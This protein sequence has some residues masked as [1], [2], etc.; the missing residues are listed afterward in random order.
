MTAQLILPAQPT[1]G[2]QKLDVARHLAGVA[3]LLS[4]CFAGEVDDG[5]RSAVREMQFLGH[6]GPLLKLLLWFTPEQNILTNGFVWVEDGRV[7]GNVSTQPAETQTGA[8]MVANVAVHPDYRRR[9]L[10]RQMMNATLEYIRKQGGRAVILQVD[11]EN[12]GAFDLYRQLGFAHLTTRRQWSRPS[13]SFVPALEPSRFDIRLRGDREW[14]EQLNLA[15]LAHPHGLAWN[16]PL[17]LSEFKPSGWRRAQMFFNN[18]AD[19]HW[20]ATTEREQVAGSVV[21][22][23][24]RPEGDRLVLMVHPA[25]R[26]QVE[27]ALLVRGL[28]RLGARPWSLRIEHPAEDTYV[29]D[30]LTDFGFGV[31]RALRWMRLVF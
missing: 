10:A 14:L 20:L 17:S 7:V 15:E 16:R 23:T 9:G 8:W 12:S 6:F 2:L 18:E 26:G 11:D 1:E 5:W 21:V 24:G 30:L 31:T 19:E 4:V 3:E 22:L 13:R 28:R 25:F 27:R 29:N